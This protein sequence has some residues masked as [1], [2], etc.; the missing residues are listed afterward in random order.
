MGWVN[1]FVAGVGLFGDALQVGAHFTS[2]TGH[3]TLGVE[4]GGGASVIL[5]GA[6]VGSL[7]TPKFHLY[8]TVRASVILFSVGPGTDRGQIPATLVLR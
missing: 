1:G 5:P 4:S 6:T 7:H 8:Q 3:I 2:T